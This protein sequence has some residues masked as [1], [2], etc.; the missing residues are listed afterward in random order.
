MEDISTLHCKLIGVNCLP[1]GEGATVRKLW[2]ERFHERAAFW[3]DAAPGDSVN[4]VFDRIRQV[5]MQQQIANMSNETCVVALFL[6]CTQSLDPDLLQALNDLPGQLHGR[7][8]CHISLCCQFCWLGEMI[9][10]ERK[11]LRERIAAMSQL[12]KQHHGRRQ[13]CLV[14]QPALAPSSEAYWKATIVCLDLLRRR[15]N[16]DDVLSPVGTGGANDDV[17]FL[18]Y[19]EYDGEKLRQLTDRQAR[20]QRSLSDQGEREFRD[21]V[22]ATFRQLEAKISETIRPDG[23]AQP[24]HPGLFVTGYFKRKKARKGKNEEYNEAQRLTREAILSTGNEIVSQCIALS[25]AIAEDAPE[26]LRQLLSSAAVGIALEENRQEMRRM[27][28]MGLQRVDIPTAPALRYNEDGYAQEITQYFQEI[29]RRGIYEAKVH[30]EKSLLAAYNAVPDDSF[31]TRRAQYRKE[32]DGVKQELSYTIQESAFCESAQRDG[33]KL[34]SGFSPRNATIGGI[35]R[36]HLLCRVRETAQ[37]LSGS[38]AH[39]GLSVSL[40]DGTAAGLKVVDSAPVKALHVL[41]FDCTPACLL[42]LIPEVV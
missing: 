32:L 10:G 3:V 17:G 35:T 15:T 33:D 26:L 13:I 31:S 37:R 7:L 41:S 20:L 1:P 28:D 2:D 23:N 9:P 12:N 11:A 24:L 42:D 40:I 16:P 30:L 38:Y 36:R 14:A 27:L 18:R 22:C 6:D 19:G 29:L 39:P 8:S 25:N 5:I 34:K 21:A 4:A